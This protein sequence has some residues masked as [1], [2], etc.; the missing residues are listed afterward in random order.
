M[1]SHN[2]LDEQVKQSLSSSIFNLLRTRILNDEYDKGDKLNELSLSKELHIS[3]TPVREALKELESEGLV[4]SI[5]NRG[6]FVKGFSPRDIDDL[7]EIRVMLEGLAIQLAIE[8]MDE[9]HLSKIKEIFDLMEYYTYKQNFEKINQLNIEFHEAIY[10]STQ[11]QYF[12][13]LLSDVHFYVSVTSRH[14]IMR[15]E[16][17]D[18]A[19]EEHKEILDTIISKDIDHAKD[20]MEKHIRKTQMLVRKYYEEKESK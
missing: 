3:R 18:T 20:V 5:P 14:S 1:P 13:Q 2:L 4:E 9:V 7:F 17:L 12:I 16:R 8:R 15:Y 6:V 19:L 10:A 11:S